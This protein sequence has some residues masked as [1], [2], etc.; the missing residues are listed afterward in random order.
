MANIN[1]I[2]AR[3]AALRDETALNSISPERAGSIMYD[4]LIALN[5]LWLQ[6]G[7]AL[8]ISKIYASVDAMEADTDPVSDISGKPLR[9]GQIVVIA[10][11]DED[12]GSVYR[13]NGTDSP[14][15]SLVGNIGNLEPVDSLD[16]DST[17]LPLAAH[18]GKV[19]D[20]KISQLGQEVKEELSDSAIS[21]INALNPKYIGKFWSEGGVLSTYAN[22]RADVVNLSNLAGKRIS[23]R[24]GT[25]NGDNEL[26]LSF[27]WIK[28]SDGTYISLS[29]IA[30]ILPRTKDA[31][32]IVPADAVELQVS[33]DE[34]TFITKE[35]S[36]Y[37]QVDAGQ[38][39]R[40]EFDFLAS[41]LQ[42]EKVTPTYSEVSGFW[43]IRST[44]PVLSTSIPSVH[45]SPIKLNK[46]DIIELIISYGAGITS[47][48]GAIIVVDSV[49]NPVKSIIAGDGSKTNFLWQANEECY[50]SFSYATGYAIV[51]SI[52]IYKSAVIEE[53]SKEQGEEVSP[54]SG[55]IWH[56]FGTSISD[57][58]LVGKYPIYLE[59]MS[60]MIRT[61]FGRSGGCIGPSQSGG[62]YILN[63]IKNDA[64]ISQAEVVTIEG[65]VNDWSQA[66]PIGSLTDTDGSVSFMGALYEALTYIQAHS[67]AQIFVFTDNTGT[68]YNE[69]DIRRT[70]VRPA[71]GKIQND[72]IEATIEMCRYLGVPVIDAG[73]ESMISQ[74]TASLY[75]MDQIHHTQLG[76]YQ[77]AKTIWD[78]MKNFHPRALSLPE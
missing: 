49:G 41:I 73:R 78:K 50:V 59:Q 20:G 77:Y 38:N 48:M 21:L 71:T 56:C 53:L 7:A 10:S 72:Y 37:V 13:Y 29:S 16:S 45:S 15:W 35:V 55:K 2:L 47:I 43:D 52:S 25:I 62:N 24:C 4:T 32:F 17:Q 18:Q 23:L 66:V 61:N 60:G 69:T 27:N 57:T 75:L 9:P 11:E 22:Y 30:T 8:V 31:M 58:D 64:N 46:S 70:V 5:E 65:F 63:A 54:Y 26:V 19:L 36:A 1:E 28:K 39:F 6:Q 51:K 44:P 3:A 74:D 42:Y 33:W 76:G 34:N 67:N 68:T 14:S 40:G 12:N